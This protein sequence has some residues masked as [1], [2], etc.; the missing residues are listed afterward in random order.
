MIHK[1]RIGIDEKGIGIDV[2]GIGDN[3]ILNDIVD[4]LLENEEDVQLYY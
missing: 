2:S 3:P 1:I 4:R